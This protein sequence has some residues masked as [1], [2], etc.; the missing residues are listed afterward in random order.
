MH[1]ATAAA[2]SGHAVVAAPEAAAAIPPFGAAIAP[3]G[4][5]HAVW[6]AALGSYQ[7]LVM[8]EWE[9]C[10]VLAVPLLLPRRPSS[11]GPGRRRRC[12]PPPR[13]GRRRR[14]GGAA[15]GGGGGGGAAAADD[16]GDGMGGE[17]GDEPISALKLLAK[18]AVFVFILGQDGGSQRLLPLLDRRRHL[19]RAD[20]PRSISSRK[21]S[22]TTASSRRRPIPPPAAA[23]AAADAAAADDTA[24]DAAAPPTPAADEGTPA[25]AAD[26]G[27][28]AAAAGAAAAAAP[29]AEA[30]PTLLQGV[31]DVAITFVLSLFPGF[32]VPGGPNAHGGVPPEQGPAI[33]A[34]PGAM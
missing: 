24:A 27:A 11:R 3:F 31:G 34:G 10:H 22:S 6:C 2:F 20:R 30:P 12:R 9:A 14:R 15:A 13:R 33:A 18:L 17:E 29:P 1:A 8:T 5:E 4:A 23:A 16:D 28:D 21:S 26:D 7:Q 25:P 32:P 19:P